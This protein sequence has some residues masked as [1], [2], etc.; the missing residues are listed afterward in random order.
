M[1]EAEK[2]KKIIGICFL[3]I[4]YAAAF[5]LGILTFLFLTQQLNDLLRLLVASC[6]TT[7]VIY[8]IG[9]VFNTTSF[10][11]PYWSTQTPI[12]MLFLMIYYNAFNLGTILFFSVFTYWATRL[13]F[14]FLKNYTGL[15]YED[16]RYKG[17]KEKCGKA[18]FLVS[19]IAFTFIPS[20]CVFASSLPMYYY[21]IQDLDFEL[22]QIIGLSI[23]T[24]AV[25]VETKADAE[26]YHFRKNRSSKSEVYAWK[27]WKYSRHPNYL[28]EIIIWAGV[29][30]VYISA[31]P[32][33]WYFVF[34]ALPVVTLIIVS[35]IISEHHYLKYKPDYKTY[36]KNT[37]AFLPIPKKRIPFLHDENKKWVTFYGQAQSKGRP[38]AMRYAKDVTLRYP[39]FVPF[40]GSHI[41]ITLDNFCVDEGVTIDHVIVARGKSLSDFQEDPMYVTFLGERNVHIYPHMELMSDPIPY[42]ISEDEYLIVNIYI[43]GCCNLTGCVDITGPLSKGY[44]AYGDQSLN[45]SLDKNTSKSMGWVHFISN[46]DVYTDNTNECVVCFGD[47]ITSQDW[48]DYMELHL[49]EMGIKNVAVVRKAVSGTRI[50]RQYD[51]I[52]YQ[53]YGL[54]GKNRFFHEVSSVCGCKKLI[55]QHGIND[56]IHPVGEDVNPFR[57]MSDMP[58]AN[59]LITG[60]EHYEKMAIRLKL[61][62]YYGN[63]LPIYNWRTFELFREDV[64]NEVNEWISKTPNFID[65]EKE[66]GE[67]VDGVWHFKDGM[68]S[69]DHLHPS[70]KAYELMG[71]LA[72]KSLYGNDM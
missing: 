28:A 20:L 36:Q 43:K 12:Y 40:G 18:Y 39:I 56:I 17:A 33:N 42:N 50:L 2:K 30:F 31:C 6:V 68:D 63:L 61:E 10:I 45:E 23:M 66:I 5:A 57:P 34:C 60:L 24:I 65:F 64:K 55:I 67:K 11:D 53:S 25:Y 71:K 72:A 54:K 51:C 59:D 29:T 16:W 58:T 15:H 1:S 3:T 27:L 49:R 21:I 4:V 70:K 62:T 8:I 47:S 52:T 13:S 46:I 22:L 7:F 69:G 9:V 26:M 14:N 48:P 38:D 37:F 35:T 44:F 32:K 41:R 19:L